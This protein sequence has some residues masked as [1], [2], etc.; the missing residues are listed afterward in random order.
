MK[1]A[2]TGNIFEGI[3]SKIFEAYPT[4]DFYSRSSGF[5]LVNNRTG[6]DRFLKTVRKENYD[7]IILSSSLYKFAGVILLKE[8]HAF[9]LENNLTPYIICLGSTIDRV[10]NHNRSI[11]GHQKK[12]LREFCNS[13]SLIGKDSGM[14]APKV[15][16]ISFSTLSD[17]QDEHPNRQCIDIDLA[18]QYIKWLID[19]PKHIC[20][21][22]ISIDAMQLSS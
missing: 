21:N 20:I 2:V 16:Y 9:C 18:V 10:S 17:K 19:Q 8:L 4:A 5:D 7:V 15:T 1:I 13:L 3:S 6:I 11:Y 12:A 14:K 22:E